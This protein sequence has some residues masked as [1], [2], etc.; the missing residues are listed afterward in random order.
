MIYESMAITYLVLATKWGLD[1]GRKR[2]REGESRN[3]EKGKERGTQ[4]AKKEEGG[5]QGL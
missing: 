1:V 4:D 5:S 3:P 2:G